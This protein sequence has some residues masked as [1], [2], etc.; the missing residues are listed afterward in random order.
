MLTDILRQTNKITC[1]S[2]EIGPS[3]TLV[4]RATNDVVEST[5]VSTATV[6][7]FD[8]IGLNEATAERGDKPLIAAESE[9]LK[10][11]VEDGDTMIV[12][13]KAERILKVGT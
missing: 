5:V 2:R 9:G 11:S 4:S 7:V 13:A 8:G 12:G 10:R 1:R 6:G 3:F